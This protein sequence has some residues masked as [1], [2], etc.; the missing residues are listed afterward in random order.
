MPR[1]YQAADAFVLA[2]LYEMFGIVLL[3]AMAS[4]LPV[5]CNDTPGFRYVVGPAGL[6]RNLERPGAL[7]SSFLEIVE[8]DRRM[9]LAAEARRH[10]ETNFSQPVVVA[11][12][13]AM[14][15]AIMGNP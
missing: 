3:E 6:Y 11:Q 15:H 9:A 12:I 1:L 13:V 8:P 5:L 10:V 4:G 14:Y 7:A 2:S